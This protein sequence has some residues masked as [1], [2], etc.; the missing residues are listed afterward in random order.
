MSTKLF[1][2]FTICVLCCSGT[3]QAQHD[4]IVAGPKVPLSVRLLEMEDVVITGQYKLSEREK[5]VQQVDVIDRKKIDGMAAQNLRDVLTNQLNIRISQDA[6]FGAGINMQGSKAYG[7]DAKILIDGVPVVG[8][9]NGAVDLTQINLA[10][11]ERI[12]IISGPM[13]VSYGTDAIAGTVN[14]ITRKSPRNSG[15]AGASTYYETIGTYN[16]SVNGGWKKGKHSIVL[17]GSRNFFG[18]WKPEDRPSFFDFKAQPADSNRVFLWKP[19]TQ[20]LGNLQYSFPLGKLEGRYKGSYFYELIT[21]RGA[22]QAPYYEQAFDNY[23]HTSRKD[24]AVF[25]TGELAPGRRINLFIAYNAYKRI[26]REVATDL[27]TLQEV[28]DVSLQDT[29]RYSELNSRGIFS[30]GKPGSKISYELGYDVNIQFANSTQISGRTREMGNYAVF[31]SAEYKPVSRFTIRPG[32]RYGYNTQYTAPVV[33]SMN[34]MYKGGSHWTYRASYAGGFRQP[35]LKELYFDFVDI[36]H[37]IHGSTELGPEYSDNMALSAVYS[38]RAGEVK[39]SL[40]GATFYN[41]IRDLITLATATGGTANEYTYVNVGRFK[42]KGLQLNAD[43]KVR[44]ISFSVGATYNG[45]YNQLSES[46]SAPAF[47]YSPELSTSLM[48]PIGKSGVSAAIFYKYT[49]RYFSY[50]LDDEDRVAQ[51][52]TDGYHTADFTVSRQFFCSRLTIAVGCK[53]LFDVKSISGVQPGGAHTGGS[54]M[55]MIGTGRY[56]FVKADLNVFKQ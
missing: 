9:Q 26:K 11:V 33:P 55:V 35:G 8:K 10:N 22:P 13:S 20:Y 27:T 40:R 56:Y 37:N 23:F 50:L 46:F 43:I 21:S 36:N 16:T 17:D 12:E 19:R 41:S 7:A 28:V 31:A 45:T 1:I 3:L 44:R 34:F 32:V 42:S 51:A 25:L 15:E 39:Y 14:I 49:G 54:N 6:I 38:G 30:A 29:S 48:C 47:S 24:N 5:A 4:S 52:V 18:G 2:G 53:N